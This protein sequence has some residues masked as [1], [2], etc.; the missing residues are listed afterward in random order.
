M[1][2][3]NNVLW[4]L[5]VGA[6][7][8]ASCS[9]GTETQQCDPGAYQC[10]LNALNQC[11]DG[12]FVTVKTCAANE[13]CDAIQ[14]G[15][16]PAC[17]D[18]DTRC[19]EDA[20]AVEIC[21][22][23]YWETERACETG[24]ACSTATRTC[25]PTTPEPD[26]K[27][28]QDEGAR[29]CD[30]DVPY[31]C[32][33]GQWQK[34]PAC[35]A[36][37][38][39]CNAQT[40]QCDTNDTPAECESG[41]S[42]EGSKLFECR[43]RQWI[44]I[45]TCLASAE[46][47]NAQTGNCDAADKPAA[48]TDGT[49]ACSD[50]RL[51]VEEC[52]NGVFS[53]KTLCQNGEACIGGECLKTNPCGE[54]APSCDGNT[55][56]QCVNGTQ[57]RTACGDNECIER[58][59]N[60]SCETH[61]C[62]D[63]ETQCSPGGE[64]LECRNNAWT[65][66]PC[67]GQQICSNGACVSRICNDGE[68][69]CRNNAVETCQNNA[70]ETSVICDSA[71]MCADNACTDIVCNDGEKQC[72]NGNVEIC[73]GNHFSTETKCAGNEKCIETG[74]SAACVKTVCAE[75]A[76]QC[77]GNA[78]QQ[79]KNNAWNTVEN[80]GAKTCD[81][82]KQTCTA[83]QCETEGETKCSKS[84]KS[85]M[86]CE[87][88]VWK[89]QTQCSTM[90]P[91]RTCDAKDGKAQ[92]IAN[93][94]KVCD[95]GT[96]C[97]GNVLKVCDNNAYISS[98][99]CGDDAKCTASGTS[100]SC[101]AYEC[102]GSGYI[103]DGNLLKQCNSHKYTV[104]KTC[105]E[106]TQQCDASLKKCADYE[107]TGDAYRCNGNTLEQCS[108]HQYVEIDACDSGKT[109]DASLRQCVAKDCKAGEY[110]CD[111]KIL[112]S[113]SR[114]TWKTDKTCKDSEECDAASKSCIPHE[115]EG[116][117]YT[118]NGRQLKQCIH[119]QWQDAALCTPQQEC[120]AEGRCIDHECKYK[121][122]T[123]YCDGT[124]VKTCR[125]YKI[126]QS[127]TCSG[128]E[129]CDASQKKCMPRNCADGDY[130]CNGQNLQ[131]CKNYSWEIAKT[132]PETQ[133][134]DAAA[135]GCVAK[136]ACSGSESRCNG[137]ILQDC[138][139]GQW[140]N[141]DCAANSVCVESSETAAACIDKWD[142]PEWCSFQYLDQRT[143]RAYGRILMPETVRAEDIKAQL[144]CGNATLPVSAWTLVSEGIVNPNCDGCGANLEFVT[145]SIAAPAGVMACAFR[146]VFGP[147]RLLCMTRDGSH[148]GGAPIVQPESTVLTGDYTQTLTTPTAGTDAVAWC[149]FGSVKN[150][151]N[152]YLQIALPNDVTPAQASVKLICGNPDAKP[153]AWGNTM[154]MHE[155][156]LCGSACSGGN[157]EFMT[158]AVKADASHK[159]AAI[160]KIGSKSYA[161]PNADGKSVAEFAPNSTL[162]DDYFQ[163]VQE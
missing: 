93:E 24:T 18:A 79:C 34:L 35:N 120:S 51:T 133:T 128:K 105:N 30:G 124:T 121:E 149:R 145:Q 10:S 81:A 72:R 1:K 161:C 21:R 106:T 71:Q 36:P 37:L 19:S 94:T 129:F 43:D 83:R 127:Q 101:V 151:D 56:V 12:V 65:A 50:D 99:N 38:E 57:I 91:A 41:F 122:E 134:C 3:R 9:D 150:G 102:T 114:N 78:L 59:V 42:C 13:W 66:Q 73:S 64:K 54:S 6:A 48:C 89:T 25:E 28:C 158:N 116:N 90:T 112:R 163:N 117:G 146:F 69:R 60:A 27:T 61:L 22:N 8:A 63:G 96:S 97:V 115:C 16:V 135:K 162:G 144:V 76:F 23:G 141:T 86:V 40:G 49:L 4:L 26:V 110:S 98:K 154:P 20:R 148:D 74:S 130:S 47:C 157:I 5:C 152:T 113:C 70:W 153:G 62:D 123:A 32:Q 67:D 15:C 100:A 80:C 58:G 125:N 31:E 46:V 92:C 33:N 55:L 75:N 136:P 82:D 132:C 29:R 68:K 85:V 84:K 143:A 140:K 156:L 119:Y 44:H 45:N 138:R 53:T 142:R 14:R 95:D 118:C 87:K 137:N 52:Q 39:T 160:V 107:C 11:T 77:D 17:D 88:G 2:N 139:S 109:C 104:R 7:L 147:E 131:V 108:D 103:C 126:I 159:C 111:G 155:N